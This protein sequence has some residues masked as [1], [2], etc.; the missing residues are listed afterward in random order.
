MIINRDHPLNASS[1]PY[2]AETSKEESRIDNI[3]V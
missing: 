3:S 2:K 1:L